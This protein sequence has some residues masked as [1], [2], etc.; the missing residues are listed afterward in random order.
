MFSHVTC[1]PCSAAPCLAGG[2]VNTK[3]V[4][5][6]WGT[7]TAAGRATQ[8]D[9]GNAIMAEWSN[10]GPEDDGVNVRLCFSRHDKDGNGCIDSL[11]LESVLKVS[12]LLLHVVL[13]LFLHPWMFMPYVII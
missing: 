5:L 9:S 1:C 3:S 6:N 13:F 12:K 4:Q 11:E 2:S 10:S 8:R 7:C